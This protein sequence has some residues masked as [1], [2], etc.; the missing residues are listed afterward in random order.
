MAYKFLN[1]D[2]STQM[3]M[4]NQNAEAAKAGWAVPDSELLEKANTAAHNQFAALVR[5]N[6]GL[7][8]SVTDAHN[9]VLNQGEGN[10]LFRG[11]PELDVR[12]SGSAE[13]IDSNL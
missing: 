2:G 9:K 4:G 6:S 11:K 5:Q 7:N 3:V 13:I 8:N 12:G 1:P 10:V